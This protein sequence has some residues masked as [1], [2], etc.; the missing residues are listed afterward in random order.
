MA[1]LVFYP[2]TIPG[3]E[4]APVQPLDRAIRH[5]ADPRESAAGQRDFS[6]TQDLKFRFVSA[7]AEIFQAWW[8]TTLVY[9]GLWFG[10]DWPLPAGVLTAIRRFTQPP[11]WQHVADGTW[12]VTAK[13]EIRGVSVP[14]LYYP[15]VQDS[16]CDCSTTAWQTNFEP[17]T[18]TL[19]TLNE[20]IDPANYEFTIAP[21]YGSASLG[22]GTVSG[23]AYN[24]RDP[25]VDIQGDWTIE[26]SFKIPA[27]VLAGVG[28]WNMLAVEAWVDP[29]SFRMWVE[30][31]D[32]D[33][34]PKLEFSFFWIPSFSQ[35]AVG[36]FLYDTRY[37]FAVV[38][39][40]TQLRVF[41]NGI[42]IDEQN[43]SSGYEGIWQIDCMF[44]VSTTVATPI[45]WDEIRVSNFARYEA[46]YATD[47]PFCICPLE[48]VGIG[49][50]ENPAAPF[51]SSPSLTANGQDDYTGAI[52]EIQPHFALLA[53]PD[54]TVEI[55]SWTPVIPGTPAP[56]IYPGDGSADFTYYVQG[57][58][59]P[60][61]TQLYDGIAHIGGPD[62]DG[63][64]VLTMY[65]SEDT[66]GYG[67]V[68]WSHS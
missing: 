4:Q 50:Y 61:T 34:T 6:G 49:W 1:D 66:G 22:W 35:H 27:G 33:G 20:Y 41:F 19:G 59:D 62:I 57:A 3:P 40:A 43:I 39:S 28:D 29:Q 21:L 45:V 37:D 48:P 65:H 68:S 51:S 36:G 24:L 5:G 63:F 31:Y 44:N 53:G 17:G 42:K 10:A 52:G 9:G 60:E 46:D 32:D 64:L 38:K 7:Q 25:A 26:G 12:D 11:Q 13:V 56:T 58:Q 47:L 30:E 2:A 14:Q 15:L 16:N 18:P 55:L 54:R 8:K 23:D 67:G